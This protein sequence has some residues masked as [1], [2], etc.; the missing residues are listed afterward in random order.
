MLARAD[1]AVAVEAIRSG[2]HVMNGMHEFLSDDGRW[3]VC[4]T[5]GALYEPA[6]GLCAA[7]PCAGDT[8]TRLPVRR[9]GE[10]LIVT[11][12]GR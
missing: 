10:A 4:A 5:H 6:T 8:L 3:I 9:A 2:L 7:G 11:C 1:R 12:P